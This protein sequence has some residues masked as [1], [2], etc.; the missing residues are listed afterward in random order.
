MTQKMKS[1]IKS[2]DDSTCII[3]QPQHVAF[4]EISIRQYPYSIS[5][6]PSVSAGV[7][8]GMGFWYWDRESEYSMQVSIYENYLRKP[9]S[10]GRCPKLDVTR[11][12]QILLGAG[13]CIDE[14]VDT[15]LEVLE[16]KK[17]RASSTRDRKWEM[18]GFYK[19]LEETARK[20]SKSPAYHI[21]VLLAYHKVHSLRMAS[22]KDRE[23]TAAYHRLDKS[24][25]EKDLEEQE[26]NSDRGRLRGKRSKPNIKFAR[27]A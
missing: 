20:L 2:S 25:D 15:V 12:A 24:N 23:S 3:S 27:M 17:K 21:R 19:V 22:A 5:D 13:Y 18:T 7:P 1:C 8:I 10:R 14:I 11:R 16:T 9:S 4:G 26:D 6:N